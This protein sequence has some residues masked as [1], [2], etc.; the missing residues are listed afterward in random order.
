[1]KGLVDGRRRGI[2]F[3]LLPHCHHDHISGAMLT[4][5]LP[6]AQQIQEM[7]MVREKV[8]QMEQTHLQLKQK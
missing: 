8:Y 5:T 3:H 7:Q 4:Y 2:S 1:M 6:V